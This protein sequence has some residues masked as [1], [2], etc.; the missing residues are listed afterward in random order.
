MDNLLKSEYP[1]QFHFP[2]VTVK[3]T[4]LAVIIP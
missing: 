4:V 1:E 2:F 3:I